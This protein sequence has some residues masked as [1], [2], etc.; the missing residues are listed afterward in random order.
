MAI[1]GKGFALT[2]LLLG[3]R[4]RGN[5]PL[6]KH[7]DG[8]AGLIV[9]TDLLFGASSGQTLIPGLFTNNNVLYAP[10]VSVGTINLTPGLFTNTQSFFA[11]SVT[12]VVSPSLFTN[13]N[14]VYSAT[15]ANVGGTQTLFPGLFTNTTLFYAANVFDPDAVS[16]IRYDI[17]TGRL[18][19]IINDY[20][21]ISL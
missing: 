18:V 1:S 2:R 14:T 13:P 7:S 12:S 20:V 4:Y 6:V 5:N 19:K 16:T 10:V 11:P 17:S 21:C 9:F 3:S 8:E 15:V